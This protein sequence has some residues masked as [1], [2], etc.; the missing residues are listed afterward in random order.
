M[1]KNRRK[2]LS[3]I[4]LLATST[5]QAAIY[6]TVDSQG[7]VSYSD[8]YSTQSEQINL[9]PAPIVRITPS[10]KITPTVGSNENQPAEAARYQSLEI[11]EPNNDASIYNNAGDVTVSLSLQPELSSGD[12]ISVSVDGKEVYK[13]TA[14]TTTLSNIDRGTHTVRA[15]IFDSKG[16]PLISSKALTF[17]LHKQ[18][19]LLNPNIN[20]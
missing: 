6:K 14:S 13:G 9:P 5:S 10:P 4:F 18:S 7:N 11:N 16:R 1:N 3:V 8:T 15:V 20:K 2:Q 12:I 19:V 17:H